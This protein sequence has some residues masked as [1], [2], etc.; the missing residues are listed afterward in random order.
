MILNIFEFINVINIEKNSLTTLK[1][2]LGIPSKLNILKPFCPIFNFIV[3]IDNKTNFF[4][5]NIKFKEIIFYNYLKEIYISNMI[6][7][8]NTNSDQL[9]L[10][11]I[12]GS[13]LEK[14]II[15]NI[16][17]GQIKSEKYKAFINFK[18]I[19]VHSIYCLNIAQNFNYQDNQ[20][21]NV[22]ITQVS[23][24]A[25][26]YDFAFKIYNKGK[27]HLKC[28]K[29]SIFKD[30]DDLERLNKQALVLDL[31][32]FNLNKGKLNIGEINSYSFAIIT[33]INVFNDYRNSKNKKNHTFFKMMKHC[34][35]NSFEFYI[36]DYFQN[37]IYTY[38]II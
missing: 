12:K 30:D 24:T 9:F 20:N 36:Y 26:F 32:N 33:S 18:E 7:Y 35:K 34:Q 8:L 2:N 6:N 31:I 13:L 17:T 5:N 25:E 19:K 29:V 4:I 3:S 15:L 16:L 11:E 28:A 23:K 27:N 21:I 37:K 14:D 38:N 22:V 1:K 10:E